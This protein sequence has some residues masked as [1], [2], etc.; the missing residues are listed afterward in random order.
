MAGTQ[1][2]QLTPL[3]AELPELGLEQEAGI[4]LPPAPTRDVQ[5]VAGQLDVRLVRERFG[6]IG[7]RRP[8]DNPSADAGY[9]PALVEPRR[10]VLLLVVGADR[11]GRLLWLLP[12][13]AG[14]SAGSPA[15]GDQTADAYRGATDRRPAKVSGRHLPIL[16]Q[17]TIHA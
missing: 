16:S 15:A 1:V 13:G 7:A 10:G 9:S 11:V 2:V 4:D 8:D 5:G 3:S 17:A 12:R 6:V 14:R